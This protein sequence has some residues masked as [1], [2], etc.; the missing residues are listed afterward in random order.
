MIF[1]VN[2]KGAVSRFSLTWLGITTY[3]TDVYGITTTGLV[4]FEGDTEST[5]SPYVITG[6][7][8]PLGGQEYNVPKVTIGMVGTGG[9]AITT[10]TNEH[11]QPQTNERITFD[12][13]G[14]DQYE[15]VLGTANA[16]RTYQLKLEI[17]A[18]TK[19]LSADIYVNPIRHRRA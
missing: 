17:P 5:V 4:K 2:P 1:A 6:E 9:A 16:A 19:V 18:D 13:A 10:T 3:N 8:Q 14:T 11:G 12:I 15:V 7:L